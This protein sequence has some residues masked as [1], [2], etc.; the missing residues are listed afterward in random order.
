[1]NA[2]TL[3]DTLRHLAELADLRG[4][5]RDAA[6]WRRM[7]VEVD[8]GESREPERLAERAQTALDREVQT[9]PWLL[10][11]LVLLGL[12]DTRA[13]AAAA[14]HGIVTL[15]D[16][17]LA[18]ADPRTA[19]P[20]GI[21]EP[22]FR[23]GLDALAFDRPRTPLGRAADHLANFTAFLRQVLPSGRD[24][25]PAG[26][27][28]RF[29]SLVE[30]LTVV[31][32]DR[33]PSRSLDLVCGL[34]Q[35]QTVR[36][37][38]ARRAIV[39][40]QQQE[41]DLRAAAPDEFGTALF[42][43]TGAV[44]HVL[45]VRARHPLVRLCAREEDVYAQAGLAWIAPELRQ[46]TGEIEAAAQGALP[47]LVSREQIRG[48]LHMHTTYS[49]GGDALP[50]MVQ[51]CAA[52]GYEYIAITDHSERAGASRTVS[53]AALQRQRQEI[54]RLRDRYPAMT[55]LHGIEVDIMPDGSL[56][57]P[58][59]LLATLDIVLAS[60][61]DHAGHDPARLTRRCL[62][63]MRHPLVNV[64]THPANRLV[65]R[66][67]GYDLA[68]DEIY[69]AAVETGTALEI[70]GAPS[71]LDLDGERAR[72]AVTA[73]AT[74]TIDSDCHRARLLD[75]QMRLGVGTARRG[76]VEAR[77]VL[78]TRPV[79]EVRAFVAAKRGRRL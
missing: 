11:R 37:R 42:A 31:F 19:A 68:F 72:A 49:D 53:P 1:M 29:E 48:D 27:V 55:I 14:R 78:N 33:D 67:S 7:A 54:A 44:A 63:A 18:L 73:G 34:P 56:D 62:Q 16:L 71:H 9:L 74:V 15:A 2:P 20:L 59:E 39:D 70:D 40:W 64:I 46:G 3:A 30:S 50:E 21:D 23:L 35:I 75:R 51:A 17:E 8:R 38:T 60:L 58:D 22:G 52:I 76:W 26:D 4:G 28:R 47:A 6:T 79:A 32:A 10:R 66:D 43:A 41:F 36:Y 12:V 69:A 13:A 65:G 57:F 45:A 25:T 5:G 77:H 24:F 61:H